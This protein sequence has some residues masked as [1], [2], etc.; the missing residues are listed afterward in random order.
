MIGKNGARQ[1]VG[2]YLSEIEYF[3]KS[4][5]ET[6][7]D[8]IPDWKGKAMD[9]I[10]RVLY[11]IDTYDDSKVEHKE[12]SYRGG[13]KFTLIRKGYGEIGAQVSFDKY[14]VMLT[15]EFWMINNGNTST[16]SY[17]KDGYLTELFFKK[18]GKTV[19]KEREND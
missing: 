7:Y 12:S 5:K 11:I 17:K 15:L 4:F 8:D 3:I 19:R 13:L 9:H 2:N 1:E 14:D 10:N 16:L 18:D 6:K